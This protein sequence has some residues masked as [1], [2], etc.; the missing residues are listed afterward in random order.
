MLNRF[1][2]DNLYKTI[3]DRKRRIVE[4]KQYK[5][6]NNNKYPKENLSC[7]GKFAN[8]LFDIPNPNQFDYD[9]QL[10][11]FYTYH[12]FAKLIIRKYDKKFENYRINFRMRH[13]QNKTL[14]KIIDEIDEMYVNFNSYG[15][16]NANSRLSKMSDRSSRS[17]ARDSYHCAGRSILRNSS[18]HRKTTM[19]SL[20]HNISEF[21]VVSNAI[22]KTPTADENVVN[23][24]SE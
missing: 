14:Y 18:R 24:L 8:I 7:F 6:E 9:Y 13:L 19:K 4:I 17:S 22:A 2:P 21:I 16:K 12:D 23:F 1:F 15:L 20:N 5:A 10:Y 3:L 11:P